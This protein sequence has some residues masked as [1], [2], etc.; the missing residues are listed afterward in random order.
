MSK[1][2]NKYDDSS[3]ITAKGG[4]M[5]TIIKLART[6]NVLRLYGRPLNRAIYDVS[7]AYSLNRAEVIQLIKLVK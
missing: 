1:V 4:Y 3:A 2:N 5:V 7:Y 6:V